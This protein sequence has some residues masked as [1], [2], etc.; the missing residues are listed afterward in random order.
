[1]ERRKKQCNETF[2]A[3]QQKHPTFFK[4]PIIQSFLQDERHWRL[5]RQAL[6][7]PTEQNRQLVDEAFQVFYGRVKALTYL[8]NLIYYNAINFDKKMKKHNDREML[9]LDQP[10]QEEDGN[11]GAT[12]KDMLY[13]PLPNIANEIACKT[14]ADHIEEPQLYQAIQNLTPKQ[15]EILTHKYVIGLQNKEIAHLFG[16]S[17]QNVFKLHKKALQKLKE[18]LQKESNNYDDN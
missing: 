1:M 9:T 18:H 14:L 6:C 10:L 2:H 12:R 13:D 7:S 8:S 15:L 5:V 11:K 3:F 4:Q 16:D 17:P